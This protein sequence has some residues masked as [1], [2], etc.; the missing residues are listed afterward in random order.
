MR[1]Q[2]LVVQSRF[3]A[4]LYQ[5]CTAALKDIGSNAAAI[6]SAVSWIESCA[7]CA[8]LAVVSMSLCPSSLPITGRV[9]PKRQ[10]AGRKA[11]S[12]VVQPD[13]LQSGPGA[14]GLPDMVEAAAA[15]A[16]VPVVAGEY[17]GAALAPRQRFQQL[18][19]HRPAGGPCV[20]RPWRLR[21]GAR[22]RGDRRRTSAG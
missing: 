12:E 11:V 2:S 9:S 19:R 5:R 13:V 17:P 22:R 21:G 20:G 3:A 15:V 8:Y 1:R 14:D 6:R 16:P 4:C 10:R 18:H 7:R